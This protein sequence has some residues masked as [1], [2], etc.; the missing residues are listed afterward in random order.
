MGTNVGGEQIT[1]TVKIQQIALRITDEEL[2]KRLRELSE[3]QHLSLNMTVNMLLG[4]AFNEVDKQK[5]DF[6]S[7]V[8]FETN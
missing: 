6:V 2:Y 5:K 8:V 7:R 1:N 3:R 4:F